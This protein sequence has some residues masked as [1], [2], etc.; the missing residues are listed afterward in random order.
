M[1]RSRTVDSFRTAPS[2]L[3]YSSSTEQISHARES[4]DLDKHSISNQ[5]LDSDHTDSSLG[6]NSHDSRRLRGLPKPSVRANV[7]T[8]RESLAQLSQLVVQHQAMK[9]NQ[10]DGDIVDNMLELALECVILFVFIRKSFSGGY[11]L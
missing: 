7:N 3:K 5:S 6:R 9:D 8:Q 2:S 11:V 4:L 10:L 1:N